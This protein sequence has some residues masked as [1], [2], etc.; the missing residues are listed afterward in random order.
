MVGYIDELWLRLLI[1]L[2]GS[3]LAAAAAYRARAL[4]GSGAWSALAMGTGFVS[5]GEPVWFGVLIAFFISSTFWSKWKRHARSKR[6]AEAKYAK[7]GRRDAGQ[8]WANGGAG[9]VLCALHAIFP[10]DGWLLAYIGVMASVNADTW[11]T[12]I[13]ALSRSVPRSIVSGKRVVTGTSG[14]IT[15]LGSA[16]ALGGAAFIGAVAALLLAIP[17][18]G[19]AAAG[20]GGYAAAGL[21]AVA[22]AAGLA[23]AFADSLLGATGQAMYRCQ[24]CGSET[25]RVSHCGSPTRHIRGFAALDNDRVNLLS[26]LVAGLLA[27]ALGQLL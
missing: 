4:S 6:D 10:H 24:V 13:G 20:M 8:V 17:Q 27:L 11:A 5:F 19:E 22:A 15:P 16:A 7:G 25:E 2:L 12:E 1:G 3:G 9:L 21:I 23:G 18:P 26:S 14:G